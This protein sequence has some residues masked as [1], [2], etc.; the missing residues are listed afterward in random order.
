MPPLLTPTNLTLAL[1][2]LNFVTFAMFGI[3]KAKAQSGRGG[4]RN[5]HS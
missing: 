2:A 5:R 3:D 4:W 1:I